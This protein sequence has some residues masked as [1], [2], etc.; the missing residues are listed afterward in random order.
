M[1]ITSKKAEIRPPSYA[2]M[3][4]LKMAFTDAQRD[5]ASNI[6]GSIS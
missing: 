5:S 3:I 4:S 6:G 1:N 2:D